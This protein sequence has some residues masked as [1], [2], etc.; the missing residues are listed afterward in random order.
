[1]YNTI[2]LILRS[3][4]LLV[5]KILTRGEKIQTGTLVVLDLVITL[6]DIA[7]LALLLIVVDFYNKNLARPIILPFEFSKTS[8]LPIVLFFFLYSLKNV[9][10]YAIL[11]WQNRFFFSIASRLSEQNM[12]RYL[13]QDHLKFTDVDSSAH[14]LEI[15]HQPIEFSTYILANVQ[16]VITQCMLITFT[17]VAIL[18]YRPVLFAWLFVLLIPPVT[19]LAYFI[20]RKLRGIRAAAKATHIRVIQYLQE[21]LASFIESNIYSKN[22]FFAD[23]YIDY[24]RQLNSNISTQQTL[25][26]LS[27]RTIEVFAVL[28]FMI[29]IAINKWATNAPAVGLLSLGVFMAAAYKI[30]PGVVKILNSISQIKT[31]AF[32][33]PGLLP[34]Q[35][36]GR[37][38]DRAVSQS[39]RS[40]KFE[41][42]SF[43][44]N[45]HSVLDDLDLEI[46]PGDFVGISGRSGLGKTTLIN[47]LLGFLSENTGTIAINGLSTTNMVRQHYWPQ[48]SYVKQQAF[49]MN[50]TVL[51]N[52]V[53]TDGDFDGD[54][55]AAVIASCGID[56]MLAQN[57]EGLNKQI[58]EDGKNVS[59][60]QRQ[61]IMF[62]RALY[63]DFD[64]LILDE[65]FSEMDEHAE[66]EMLQTLNILAQQG[67][68]IV[69]ITHNKTSL[70]YCSKIIKLD[71]A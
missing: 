39:I 62:A 59:G 9:V 27:S 48:I 37:K 42:V 68:M 24:Q 38:T 5:S 66:T 10:A 58:T 55:L 19:V 29:L 2:R 64:L 63:H 21:A 51:K 8:L 4:I 71:E 34:E 56:A 32:I 3:N 57:P 7:F 44:Y 43:K 33:L 35:T 26:A 69:L 13:N 54:K 28:G 17:V 41:K 31:Y 1:L 60:G 52:I 14:V 70:T 53:L 67:K 50:D 45:H 49:F 18:C 36:K 12:W 47:L 15:S 6:L 46:L 22:A 23:R 16:Q 61:R 20:K 40:I 11:Q 25:Q 65:P 30:I